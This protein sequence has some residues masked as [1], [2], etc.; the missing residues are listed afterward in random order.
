MKPIYLYVTP[1]FPSA[2]CWRGGFSLDSV[3][4]IIKEGEYDVK[5]M[6][7]G[8]G[9][10]YEYDGVRVCRFSRVQLPCT[11]APFLT[12]STNRRRFRKA[13]ERIGIKPQDIAICHVNQM[14]YAEYGA[15]VKRLNPTATVKLQHHFQYPVHVASGRL[16]VIPFHATLLYFHWRR[17]CELMDVHAFVGERSRDTFWMTVG[18]NG[19]D[20]PLQRRLLFGSLFRPVKPPVSVIEHIQ[21]N[22][23][24][25]LD[26]GRVA[27]EGFA[28]GCA[29]NFQ[30]LKDQITLIKAVEC[31]V[32]K[33][34][35]DI[36]LRLVG[37]GAMRK[38][39][40]RYVRENNLSSV[41][42]FEDE[43]PHREM[44]DFYRE[45]DL[46][47]LPSRRES[48]SAVLAEAYACGTPILMCCEDCGFAETLPT[49]VLKKCAVP[50]GDVSALADRISECIENVANGRSGFQE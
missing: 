12:E 7:A 14:M 11:L 16:G 39:C 20:M 10:D 49:D 8:D 30:P 37:S 42:S 2:E 13:L 1:F 31:V 36:R 6:T 21:I 43:R 35:D 25:F 22:R 40:E 33:G 47:V 9:D 19:T 46:F 45:L 23:D 4:A 3:K 15:E 29:A 28:I 5:V 44:P 26:K 18:K 50:P 34:M 48:Y 27:H 41:V 24:I 32:K 38:M 17:L